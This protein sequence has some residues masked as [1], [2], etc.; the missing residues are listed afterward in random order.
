MSWT[1]RTGPSLF[2]QARTNGTPFDICEYN[3]I[4]LEV[5]QNPIVKTIG[6]FFAFL[7]TFCG[8]GGAHL[9]HRPFLW[10]RIVRQMA[11]VLR[12]DPIQFLARGFPQAIRHHLRLCS[13]ILRSSCKKYLSALAIVNLRNLLK[14]PDRSCPLKMTRYS[15]THTRRGA[16]KHQ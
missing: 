10:Q 2:R 7:A 13:N 1:A 6:S 11:T 14:I 4:L 5:Q 15:C 9:C 3:W 12:D 8:I 16:C